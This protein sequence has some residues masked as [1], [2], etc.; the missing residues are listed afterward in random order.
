[1]NPVL[2]LRVSVADRSGALAQAATVIGL[3]GGNIRSIDVHRADTGS[4]VDDLVVEF[5]A[6]PDIEGM[7]A[8]LAINAT[9]TLL[10]CAPADAVDP[11]EA[12]LGEVL[13]LLQGGSFLEAV[14]GICAAGSGWVLDGPEAVATEVG[15]AAVDRGAVA[16]MRTDALPREVAAE[17]GQEAAVLAVP[18]PDQK[19]MVVFVARPA[20]L[21]FTDTEVARVEALVAIQRAVAA[22]D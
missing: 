21:G 3:H 8:D 5:S 4:A 11:V 10:A 17:V 16:W 9:A 19:G 20:E 12:S 13:A 7:R 14:G 6:D 18:V 1:V 2:R 15:R 22:R